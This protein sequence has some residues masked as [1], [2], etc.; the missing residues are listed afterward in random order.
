MLRGGNTET[1]RGQKDREQIFRGSSR[2][3]RVASPGAAHG[4]LRSLQPPRWSQKLCASVHTHSPCY[5]QTPLSTVLPE[6]VL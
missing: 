5:L 1:K 6:A 3:G 2:E 4:E